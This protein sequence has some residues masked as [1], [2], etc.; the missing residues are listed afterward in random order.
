[1]NRTIKKVGIIGCGA[2]GSR[3]AKFIEKNLSK[4]SEIIALSDLDRLAAEKLSQQLK[5]HPNI[6]EVN[7]LIN[8]CD[9][10]IES[11]IKNV[12]F[13]IAKTALKLNKEV[14]IM[15]VGGLIGHGDISSLL[16]NSKGKLYIPS[17]AICGLDAFKA[18]ALS[19]VNKVE[20]CTY[21]SVDGL[22]TSPFVV[23]NKINLK[24]L[25]KE[26]MIFSGGVMEAVQNFP[27]NINVAAT[28]S[29]L[30]K[31]K[32]KLKIKI[33][34]GPDIKRNIHKI[35]FYSN[36][37]MVVAETYNVVCPDNPKTSYLAVLSAQSVLKNIFSSLRMGS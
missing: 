4:Y 36:A 27:A 14:L 16:A 30:L 24:A 3:L 33:F 18:L 34:T 20:L 2:I 1:M 11:A 37:G 9:L 13:E 25:K 31:D 5:S 35:K 28:L 6:L 8:K 17:G 23:N 32:N 29:L 7:K 21:K 12:S 15:S 22:K 19:G 10:V 26:T